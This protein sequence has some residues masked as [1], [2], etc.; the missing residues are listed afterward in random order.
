MVRYT[1]II[2]L[3]GLVFFCSSC[4]TLFAT[5]SDL[6]ETGEYRLAVDEIQGCTLDAAA[7]A[8]D[9]HLIVSGRM[10]FR[11]HSDAPLSGDVTG[12]IVGP[13][14]ARIETKSTPF[15][16]YPHGRHLHPAAKFA[17]TF[18]Q[19]PPPG[20]LVKLSHTLRPFDGLEDV[21]PIR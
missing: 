6:F 18:D 20:S 2:P 3:V 1:S 15:K 5:R 12:E 4:S 8:Q 14:G 13:N 19:I 7:S 21:Q 16:A 10:T 11:H 9:G 17:L